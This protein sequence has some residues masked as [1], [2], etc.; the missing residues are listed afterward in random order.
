LLT[1]DASRNRCVGV[2]ST[3]RTR[4]AVNSDEEK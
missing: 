1:K 4:M 2:S 3:T